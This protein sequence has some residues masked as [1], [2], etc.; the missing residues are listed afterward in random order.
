MVLG[1]VVGSSDAAGNLIIPIA[2]DDHDANRLI[3]VGTIVVCSAIIMAGA[4]FIVGA[5][6]S[7]VLELPLGNV[8]GA[9]EGPV[10]V[11]EQAATGKLGLAVDVDL[12]GGKRGKGNKGMGQ[13]D[14]IRQLRRLP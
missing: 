14:G 5:A 6:T 1:L 9:N 10:A 11:A 8:T 12:Y 4:G 2:I 7:E 3:L 13:K